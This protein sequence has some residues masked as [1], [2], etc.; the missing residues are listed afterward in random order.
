MS[1]SFFCNGQHV[2]GK[3]LTTL[4]TPRFLAKPNKQINIDKYNDIISLKMK[5]EKN[6]EGCTPAQ[7]IG[8][9]LYL[10]EADEDNSMLSSSAQL[11]LL[12]A[13]DWLKEKKETLKR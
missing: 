9:A 11:H 4:S 2:F 8:L 10:L 13:L 12:N 6:P 3:A 5:N 7:L 1:T